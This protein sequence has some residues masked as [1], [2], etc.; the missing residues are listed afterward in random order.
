MLTIPAHNI[1]NRS[2][3]NST[4]NYTTNG[5]S[6][7]TSPPPATMITTTATPTTSTLI[8]KPTTPLTP[9]LPTAC[10]Q[11]ATDGTHLR[12]ASWP[13][14]THT[15]ST[16]ARPSATSACCFHLFFT[17]E[18]EKLKCVQNRVLEGN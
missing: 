8:E 12:H 2:I 9:A 13:V 6:N 14:L 16:R 4:T 7:T 10:Q 15:I 5:T 11:A 17:D 1:D 3:T 18:T